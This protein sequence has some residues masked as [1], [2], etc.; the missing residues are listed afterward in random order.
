MVK[1]GTLKHDLPARP[2]PDEV[3]DLLVE[4]QDLRIERMVSTG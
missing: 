3:V 2:L 1:T 4:R